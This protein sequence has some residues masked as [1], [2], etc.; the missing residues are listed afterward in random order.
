MNPAR[1]CSVGRDSVEPGSARGGKSTFSPRLDGVSPYRVGG[2]IS[3]V[4]KVDP[5]R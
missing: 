2:A 5:I 4:H 3:R 1:I